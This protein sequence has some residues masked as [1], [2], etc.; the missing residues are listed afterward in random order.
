[1]SLL[2][3]TVTFEAVPQQDQLLRERIRA[4]Y[5]EMP[6]MKLTLSQAAKLFNVERTRCA[7][8]LAR[9]VQ[10][11]ALASKEG[12]FALPSELQSPKRGMGPITPPNSR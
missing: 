12:L 2:L 6:G 10:D 8:L 3:D 5:H 7:R 11:G 1:M 4:E 9:L